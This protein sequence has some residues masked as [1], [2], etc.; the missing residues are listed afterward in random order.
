MDKKEYL[1]KEGL[2]TYNS[3]INGKFTKLD[4]RV[5]TL[6]EGGEVPVY[7]FDG[8]VDSE[9]NKEMFK[10][11]AN[12]VI[13]NK[14]FNIF[15]NSDDPDND[16]EGVIPLLSYSLSKNKKR[17]EFIFDGLKNRDL[18]DN[19]PLL[20][21]VQ[22]EIK[23]SGISF[24]I[25][26]TVVVNYDISNDTIDVY[27]KG[28]FL[29]NDVRLRTHPYN[30]LVGFNNT[31]EWTPTHDYNPVHKKYVD[32][33]DIKEFKAATP[34]SDGLIVINA[35]TNGG[36]NIEAFDVY[37]GLDAKYPNA[38]LGTK[39][40][41]ELNDKIENNKPKHFEITL[42]SSEWVKNE[43]RNR[44]EYTINRDDITIN[45]FVDI[46]M[47]L[48]ELDKIGAAGVNTY[49]KKIVIATKNQPTENIEISIE[50]Q[51][52]EEAQ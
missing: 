46:S 52:S 4:D 39:S 51:L 40:G 38:A 1:N 30:Q 18:S 36:T 11:I 27:T 22:K 34:F 24:Y 43:E 8:D 2:I 14:G 17:I 41:K 12:K 48:E 13:E 50:Y 26:L 45:T 16:I 47:E 25:R 33:S 3:A 32:N 42:L 37:N 29:E 15:M 49:D 31:N 9:T 6:E 7:Y 19:Y 20:P 44:Y 28:D 5:K 10:E 23:N 35:V 21:D